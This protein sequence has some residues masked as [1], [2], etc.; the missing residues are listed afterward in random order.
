MD[1]GVRVGPPGFA[2]RAQ[3]GLMICRGV[4]RKSAD[5][6][7]SSR[8]TMARHACNNLADTNTASDT[9]RT[10]AQRRWCVGEAIETCRLRGGYQFCSCGEV[11]EDDG[12]LLSGGKQ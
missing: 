9:P 8:Q 10:G 2:C 5:F 4:P 7:D 1:V 11:D 6:A 3:V 12:L